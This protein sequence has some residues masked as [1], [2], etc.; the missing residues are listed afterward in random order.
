MSLL[1]T[2]ECIGCGACEYECPTE[3]ITKQ[4]EFFGR[5]VIDQ[6]A[7]N[8]CGKCADVCPVAVVVVDESSV[9]CE[10]RGCPVAVAGKSKVAGWA[11]NRASRRC[12]ACG[13]PAWD[14]SDGLTGCPRCEL[15][16]RQYCP[17]FGRVAI[18]RPVAGMAA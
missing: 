6:W 11:C 4:D 3:A 14:G 10:G 18:R 7:C 15:G 5:F 8:D 2:D 16:L 12:P 1:I 17:K 9:I 13:N